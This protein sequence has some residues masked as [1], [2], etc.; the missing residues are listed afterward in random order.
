MPRNQRTN[1]A[2]AHAGIAY[3]R[4]L[5]GERKRVSFT[6]WAEHYKE[7]V[8]AGRREEIER[9]VKKAASR[10]ERINE[11]ECWPAATD[12]REKSRE[13][14][15]RRMAER[16]G[17]RLKK[18]RQRDPKATDFGKYWLVGGPGDYSVD[19]PDLD[20]VERYLADDER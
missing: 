14:R 1:N 19:L 6:T 7:P 13:T 20:D 9:L 17:L 3:L 4:H 16:R 2:E 15:L 18:S 8:R 11:A 10:L 5:A 12:T